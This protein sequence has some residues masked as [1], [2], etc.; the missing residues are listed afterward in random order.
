VPIPAVN[1]TVNGNGKLDYVDNNGNGQ[2]DWD[3]DTLLDGMAGAG[4]AAGPGGP[5][6]NGANMD[7]HG[8]TTGDMKVY[9]FDISTTTLVTQEFKVDLSVSYLKKYFTSLVFAIDPVT[10]QLWNMSAI[11]YSG[12]DATFSPRWTVNAAFT[13]TFLLGNGGMITPTFDTRYQTSYKMYFL[14]QILQTDRDRV[15]DVIIPVVVDVSTAG[16]Q[17]AYHLSNFSMVYSNPSGKWTLTGYVKNLEN[18]AVKR[19]IFSA[20][21]SLG[22]LTIG[23]PRTYGAILSVRF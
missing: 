5:G 18:Y 14:D 12:S 21:P 17:E 20:G 10:Q 2:F 15:N 16:I 11:D 13:Y 9:G 8:K 7:A 3:T 22:E 1:G 19:S 4:G 23:P 6:A